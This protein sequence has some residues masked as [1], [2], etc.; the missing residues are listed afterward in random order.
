M[1]T[2]LRTKTLKHFQIKIFSSIRKKYV[3]LDTKI[4][5]RI[6]MTT[7]T[8]SQKDCSVSPKNTSLSRGS[9]RGK[10]IKCLPRF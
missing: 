2:F 3:I 4:K 7:N 1:E 8:F 6:K 9:K 10:S 5:I